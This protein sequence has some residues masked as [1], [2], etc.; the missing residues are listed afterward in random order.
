MAMQSYDHL[1]DVPHSIRLHMSSP[2][3]SHFS[4]VSDSG[5]NLSQVMSP[6]GAYPH[7]DTTAS[8]SQQHANAE[9]PA[10][11]F[12]SMAQLQIPTE[13]LHSLQHLASVNLGG[14]QDLDTL[15][16]G[17]SLLAQELNVRSESLSKAVTAVATLSST[18]RDG[19]VVLEG[20]VNQA[21][22]ERRSIVTQMNRMKTE[23]ESFSARL[24]ALEGTA[25]KLE[26]GFV[27]Q[28]RAVQ[29][30]NDKLGSMSLAFDQAREAVQRLQEKDPAT[31]E[32]AVETMNSQTAVLGAAMARLET[33]SRDM[34]LAD[35][36][37]AKQDDTSKRELEKLAAVEVA[38][39]RL[40]ARCEQ[41]E[42][43]LEER[44]LLVK[45]VTHPRQTVR[46]QQAVQPVEAEPSLKLEPLHADAMEGRVQR[47][48][49]SPE[50]NQQPDMGWYT[51]EEEFGERQSWESSS[52]PPGL[53]RPTSPP[54][55][56][57]EAA[58][59]IGAGYGFER[60]H[61]GQWKMLKDCP[62]LK[63]NSDEPWERGLA[64]RQWENET[65]AIAAVVA[66]SFGAFFRRRMKE[67][68]D[69][70]QKRQSSGVE[71][72][73]PVIQPEER[74][75]ET[76]L[77]VTLIKVLPESIRQPVMERSTSLEEPLSTLLLLE[78]VVERFSPGGT[79]EM[80][81]LLQYQRCLPTATSYKELLDILRKFDLARAR[82]T[83]LQLPGLPAHEIIK[84]LDGLS[85]ALERKNAALAMRLNLIRMT[86]EVMM[87]S[88]AGVQ[89]LITML[90]Q[91]GR[92]LQAEDEIS[93][94]K[95]NQVHIENPQAAQAAG[96]PAGKGK[97][98]SPKD[99]LCKYYQMDRGCVKGDACE[100]SHAAP[101]AAKSKGKGK[102]E[103]KTAA[104]SKPT[105]KPKVES[106][107]TAEP[108][109]PAEAKAATKF[110][111]KPKPKAEAKAA[112][113]TPLVGA[114]A[115]VSAVRS[116]VMAARGVPED[117][118]A[119]T[120]RSEVLSFITDQSHALT[121]D[122]TFSARSVTVSNEGDTSDA[123]PLDGV[124]IGARRENV[125]PF[126][127]PL[128]Y[129]MMQPEEFLQWQKNSSWICSRASGQFQMVNSP[130][131]IA[132]GIWFALAWEG[133][134]EAAS[135]VAIGEGQ[136]ILRARQVL[137]MHEDQTA[138]PG[139]VIWVMDVD[140]GQ[141]QFLALSEWDTAPVVRPWSDPYP[142]D[143]QPGLVPELSKAA[144]PKAI[145]SIAQQPSITFTDQAL[146]K[147][148]SGG[149][150]AGSV[151]YKPPPPKRPPDFSP[152]P[153]ESIGIT[154]I[155]NQLPATPKLQHP[156]PKQ[157]PP[158]TP[159]QASASAAQPSANSEGSAA[160]HA[161]EE[162]EGEMGLRVL[163][164]SG[165]NEIIRPVRKDI[166]RKKSVPMNVVLAS[167]EIVSGFRTKEGEVALHTSSNEWILGVVRVIEVGGR[168]SWTSQEA[169]IEYPYLGR[170]HSV[171]CSVQ[172]GLPYLSW[173][174]FSQ[175]RKVLSKHWQS[176]DARIKAA[177]VSAC[178]RE[179]LYL[180][181]EDLT[182]WTSFEAGANEV[183]CEEENYDRLLHQDKLTKEDVQQAFD[184]AGLNPNH[185]QYK[186]G[187]TLGDI[188]VVSELV[189]L[190]MQLSMSTT[191]IHL[192]QAKW[193]AQ[194]LRKRGLLHLV[195]CDSLP[196]PREG[197]GPA[198][199]L[200]PERDRMIK[201]CQ[202]ELGSLL[203]LSLRSRPDV[204]AVVGIAACEITHDPRE[205]MRLARGVW[206]YIR[207]T[208]S[209]GLLYE[210][211]NETP[212]EL[213][214]AS[215]AS[216]SPGGSRSRSGTVI[217]W[218]S[219]VI[220]WRS[221]RQTLT[222][223]SAQEAELEAM[224]Q[225][226]ELGTKIYQLLE[227]IAGRPI[228]S[229]LEA[230]NTA[231]IVAVTKE[232]WFEAE[233]RTRH[234]AMRTAWLRD[235]CRQLGLE[236]RHRSGEELIADASTKALGKQKL[237]YFANRLLGP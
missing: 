88:E 162:T 75:Y 231:A 189:F 141:E 235:Q 121:S 43:A 10:I 152:R 187:D 69:R 17:M 233:V 221:Q 8:A 134:P 101:K 37:I 195:G 15:R 172:N 163:V 188:P 179:N 168:F 27:M 218:G 146:P 182:A 228:S 23:H 131:A 220:G 234:F 209:R 2:A 81:S 116:V 105:P 44:D 63:L 132:I 84:S 97:G 229:C 19:A 40:K 183:R 47:F 106:K 25:S 226:V 60:V 39:M 93:K 225:T 49:L 66:P 223:Y 53:F 102:G 166:C 202:S 74:E 155:N 145:P 54:P 123:D 171:R 136:I 215:D 71:E 6:T 160:K 4:S 91:E 36:R 95:S 157:A 200:G 176:N 107:P 138:R 51:T 28:Q 128:W 126:R 3:P 224:A 159:Q 100:F 112:S 90:L 213:T 76:R 199:E 147:A 185:S 55:P 96:Q 46:F 50:S 73:V 82:T 14:L 129:L 197:K 196:E 167:G 58:R 143:S 169:L 156:P 33:L 38:T 83:Y 149:D 204:A 29:E 184:L 142:K 151:V 30:M 45:T 125:T 61:A 137:L 158:N 191:G 232:D 115:T 64:L 203:W 120:E 32:T 13:I 99:I 210:W 26:E 89:R 114:G 236:V 178:E 24:L 48:E 237:T 110:K 186:V 113:A 34:A 56:L 154:P 164:D 153:S 72:E 192:K 103:G 20:Q 173:S 31:L 148:S 161:R 78:S 174:Q 190:G 119:D 21:A 230:D 193:V 227:A 57:P 35:E 219:H 109:A 79:S 118:D 207:K 175:I 86:P 18:V 92:R 12:R 7:T 133:Y 194:E 80:T 41:I 62:V 144:P 68:L 98:R 70:Y 208:W 104:K 117:E 135:D 130:N 67:A 212:G 42:K 108:T 177:A 59:R 150:G 222:A 52:K 181:L 1:D 170:M 206:R 139:Y 216:L 217:L 94:G 16:Q 165:A 11:L 85:K 124:D 22:D 9:A 201:E 180:K 111:P 127:K 77:G 140:T 87:P 211:M 65:G 122:E 5:H 198:M 214:W 205:A